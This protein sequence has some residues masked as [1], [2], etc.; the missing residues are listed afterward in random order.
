MQME[1]KQR[2]QESV[3]IKPNIIGNDNIINISA[4]HTDILCIRNFQSQGSLINYQLLQS[5]KNIELYFC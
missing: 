1:G 2:R 5:T 4:G 3:G